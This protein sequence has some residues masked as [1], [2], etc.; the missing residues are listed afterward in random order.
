[1]VIILFCVWNISVLIW[2][3]Q[4]QNSQCEQIESETILL[5]VTAAP[6]LLPQDRACWTSETG[7]TD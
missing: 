6:C 7:R 4:K 3:Q 1:M 5:V 2:H